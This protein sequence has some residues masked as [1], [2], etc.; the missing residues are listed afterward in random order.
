MRL[1]GKLDLYIYENLPY[2]KKNCFPAKILQNSFF[3]YL[4]HMFYLY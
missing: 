1:K 2:L 3:V 4:I